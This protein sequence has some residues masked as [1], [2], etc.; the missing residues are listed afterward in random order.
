VPETS[1]PVDEVTDDPVQQPEPTK[2]PNVPA[3]L[4]SRNTRIALIAIASMLVV[5]LIVFTCFY[6]KFARL[7]NEKLRTGVFA[8]SLNIFAEPRVLAIGDRLSLTDT[9]NYLR[10]NGYGTSHGNPLGW[11]EAQSSAVAIFPGRDSGSDQEPATIHFSGDK[12][13]RIVSL[14]DNTQRQ[15]YQL[16][17]QL[18]TNL[19]ERSRE[20]RKL[21]RF[22]EMAIRRR[23]H[24]R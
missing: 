2:Q 11:Y 18:I 24:P 16:A 23:A 3:W 7:T 5:T 4:T 15:E 21:V 1:Y 20:Q 10:E 14:S 13:A 17:P 19:A 6:V 12:V 9:I 22:S 8:G